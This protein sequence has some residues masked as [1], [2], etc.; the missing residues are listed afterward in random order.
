MLSL[1]LIY[2]VG[3]RFYGTAK[4]YN[5][6]GWLYAILGVLSYYGGII[7]GGVIL[8]IIIGLFYPESLDDTSNDLFLGLLTI[9]VGILVCWGFYEIL[10]NKWHKEYTEQERRKPRIS[11]IG[12]TEDEIKPRENVSIGNRSFIN[13]TKKK[14]NN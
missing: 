11:D 7:I 4:K 2:F 14:D 5:Q 1:V 3:K 8:A 13:L 12:K 9:P 10:K 6:S